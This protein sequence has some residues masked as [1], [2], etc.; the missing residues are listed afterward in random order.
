MENKFTIDG[1]EYTASK[2][3]EG[4]WSVRVEDPDTCDAINNGPLY[5]AGDDEISAALGFAVKFHDAGDHPTAIEAIYAVI[6]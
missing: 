1:I 2:L 5:W 3:D 4:R 6:S